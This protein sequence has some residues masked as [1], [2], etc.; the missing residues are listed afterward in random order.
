MMGYRITLPKEWE[1]CPKWWRDIVRVHGVFAVEII[2]APYKAYV[3]GITEWAPVTVVVFPSEQSYT[4][5]L[6]KWT[7]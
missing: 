7:K 4:M 6:L 1:N 5:F 2:L 3:I